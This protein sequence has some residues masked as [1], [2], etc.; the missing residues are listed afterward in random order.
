[1]NGDLPLLLDFRH[2]LKDFGRTCISTFV[3]GAISSFKAF[4]STRGTKDDRSVWAC[5]CN[6]SVVPGRFDRESVVILVDVVI[7]AEPP[8]GF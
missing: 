6:M 4:P 3:A 7:W 1:M 8:P 2:L 5:E